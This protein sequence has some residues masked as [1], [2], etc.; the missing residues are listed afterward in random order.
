MSEPT[1][2]IC[3]WLLPFVLLY[4]CF[5]ICIFSKGGYFCPRVG[6]AVQYSE[7][8]EAGEGQRKKFRVSREEEESEAGSGGLK[9]KKKKKKKSWNDTE[10]STSHPLEVGYLEVYFFWQ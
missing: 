9:V 4:A 5:S 2:V 3:C 1:N 10:P 6:R 8:S 7:D